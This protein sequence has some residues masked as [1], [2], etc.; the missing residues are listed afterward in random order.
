MIIET[1]MLSPQSTM[2]PETT[3]Y[4]FVVRHSLYG[5]ISLAEPKQK[6]AGGGHGTDTG[7]LGVVSE[8]V[9][10]TSSFCRLAQSNGERMED[11]H[12]VAE[13]L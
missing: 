5:R 4:L 11:L 9:E 6:T 1:D 7:T 3:P 10:D 13:R 12:R 8:T 2:P